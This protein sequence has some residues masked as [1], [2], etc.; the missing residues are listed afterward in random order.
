MV[1]RIMTGNCIERLAELPPQSVHLVVTSPPYFPSLRDYGV[2]AVEWPEVAYSPMWG[3]PELC[4]PAWRGS[5]GDEPDPFAYIGHLV[6]VMRE[7]RR[8]LRP[9]S[10]VW[11]NIGD[12][13]VQEWRKSVT[14]LTAKQRSSR[15]SLDILGHREM[16]GVPP[17]GNLLGIPS[18]LFHALQADG[19]IV[20]AD[21]DWTKLRS[22]MVESVTSRPTMNR[23]T[24][25]MLTPAAKGYYFDAV[26]AMRPTLPESIV[27]V[28]RGHNAVG[29]NRNV[30][31]GKRQ[32]S[33]NLGV[34]PH[35]TGDEQR[36]VSPLR[37][38]RASDVMSDSLLEC[39][40]Q[41]E[42]DAA[43]LCGVVASG[44]MVM[45]EDG[46]PINLCYSVQPN[47]LAHYASFGERMI[48]DIVATSSPSHVCESCGTGWRRVWQHRCQA[49]AC[50]EWYDT[51]LPACP[52]CGYSY[53]NHQKRKDGGAGAV[54]GNCPPK[55]DSADWQPVRRPTDEFR[56]ACSCKAN[57]G[58]GQ[59]NVLDPFVGSGT[60]LVVADRL[61]REGIGIEANLEYA[62][63]SYQRL[64]TDAPLLAA[65]T[66]EVG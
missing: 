20:R 47:K 30:P 38:W 19:W 62:Q 37:N 50:S 56:P 26:P 11:L 8:V 6:Q 39:A 25:L 3:L 18:R 55:V 34:R 1:Q 14:H 5:L 65:V 49:E 52:Q 58:S 23:E 27:R 48:T 15:G 53:R 32:H 21:P 42:A 31:P 54:P 51:H 61:G 29:H 63:M 59:A 24:W 35:A 17:R 12:A 13:Y 22:G 57:T 40:A 66:A 4:I 36:E 46:L 7:M 45:D 16:R 33:M 2:E 9:D 60:T 44:G 43:A 41:L 10:V 64:T 28:Q